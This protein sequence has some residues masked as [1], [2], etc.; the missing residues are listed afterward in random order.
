MLR[1]VYTRVNDKRGVAGNGV[2]P[3]KAAGGSRVAQRMKARMA[4]DLRAKVRQGVGV[5]L[6]LLAGV[7]SCGAGCARGMAGEERA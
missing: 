2:S 5:A 6:M 7:V 1:R 3:D 4:R